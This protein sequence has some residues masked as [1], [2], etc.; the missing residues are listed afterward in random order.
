[1]RAVMTLVATPSTV[2]PTCVAST[3]AESRT[4]LRI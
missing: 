3:D 1:M 4:N 2:T